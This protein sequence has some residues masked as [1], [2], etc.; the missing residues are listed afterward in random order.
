[1][2][3]VTI[4]VNTHARRLGS[5][6]LECGLSFVLSGTFLAI[7]SELKHGH[8]TATGKRP[9][10]LEKLRQSRRKLVVLVQCCN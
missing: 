4:L 5:G 10:S 1:M 3:T 8:L 6:F 9:R 2:L 7:F